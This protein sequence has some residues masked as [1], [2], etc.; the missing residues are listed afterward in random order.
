MNGVARST[1]GYRDEGLVWD[2]AL[3]RKVAEAVAAAGWK[4]EEALGG[5]PVDVEGV[6]MEDGSVAVVQAR[7]QVLPA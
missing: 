1:P 4:V 6:V 2:G 7:P 3:Q 5:K